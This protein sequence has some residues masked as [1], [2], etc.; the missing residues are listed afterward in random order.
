M[1]AGK[2]LLVVGVLILGLVVV[3]G[4]ASMVGGSAGIDRDSPPAP[5]SRTTT[6]TYV[7]PPAWTTTTT[8]HACSWDWKGGK[9]TVILLRD[10]KEVRRWSLPLALTV[11]SGGSWGL[12]GGVE[13]NVDSCGNVFNYVVIVYVTAVF[14][15]PIETPLPTNTSTWAPPNIQPP[16]HPPI[17]PLSVLEEGMSF[18]LYRHSGEGNGAVKLSWSGSL[19]NVF[20]RL[21]DGKYTIKV[22]CEIDYVAPGHALKKYSDAIDL[23]SFVVSG[24]KVSY[25]G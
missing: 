4:L 7:P 18:E 5:G 2:V 6:S 17:V 8:V 11:R 22:W 20:S 13:F 16:N 9:F 23:G 1:K 15:G 25:E 14:E 12:K 21:P 19:D 10:G 24:G 3:V